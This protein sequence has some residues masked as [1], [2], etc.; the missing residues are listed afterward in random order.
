[1]YIICCSSFI[2][3]H[4]QWNILHMAR[5]LVIDFC[6]L[7]N[8]QHWKYV[9]A[10]INF[11]LY[12]Q[13]GRQHPMSEPGGRIPT[14]QGPRVTTTRFWL[15]S[16]EVWVTSHHSMNLYN[17]KQAS[18]QYKWSKGWSLSVEFYRILQEE[19]EFLCLNSSSVTIVNLMYICNLHVCMHV[20][21]YSVFHANSERES[22]VILQEYSFK[23]V[24]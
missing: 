21:R 2:L 10:C 17:S 11:M 3:L 8:D 24:I 1:V 20:K 7:C 9:Y 13:V 19:T 12:H 22:W 18:P 5:S 6:C 16:A 14:S 15:S 23:R 4:K